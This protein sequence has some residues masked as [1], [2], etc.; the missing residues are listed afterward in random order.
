MK[1]IFLFCSVLL[2]SIGASANN[3]QVS[4]I[5]YNS[6]TG[7]VTFD[8]GWENSWRVST[9][10]NNWDAAWVFIKRRN[11]ADQFW[12]QQYIATSG[13]V[14]ASPLQ[15]VT[16]PDSVGVFIQRSAN[17][18]GNI[19]ATTVTLKLGVVPTPVIEWDFKVFAV[20]M[21]YVPQ[22]AFY[23]GSGG[24][25]YYEF[26]EGNSGAPGTPYLV[27]SENAI[28][29]ANTAGNLWDA[30]TATSNF[31]PT[32]NVVNANFPK[33][34]RAFYAMKYEVT[35]GQ[36]TDFL[37]SLPQD[38]AQARQELPAGASRNNV[39]GTWPTY[40]CTTPNR[41]MNYLSWAD[42]CA[43]LDWSGLAPMSEMEYE[44]L[45]RGV[46]VPVANEFAWGTNTATRGFSLVNDGTPQEEATNAITVGSGLANFNGNAT[47]PSGVFRVGFAAKS[48]TSRTEAGAGY[49]GNMDLTGNVY[50]YCT[51]IYGNATSTFKWDAHGDGNLSLGTGFSNVNGWVNQTIKVEGAAGTAATLKGGG[52]PNRI[53]LLNG[54][55]Q[56]LRVS[57]RLYSNN[58][59]GSNA[60]TYGGRG[61]RRVFN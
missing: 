3:I 55:D 12:K 2:L 38:M 61:V 51:S 50:E 19:S 34:F 5:S 43:Y 14:A 30:G 18:S 60:S 35:Q 58:V 53:G 52:W 27:N 39:T 54:E 13:H 10:P 22:S 6:G 17:G 24:T 42:L 36:Y 47:A 9:I 28:T 11:C 8:I 29:F 16:V 46:S 45:C 33:G 56:S 32:G 57:D 26:R 15:V 7:T 44:K 23:L 49:Y 21:T 31:A 20:E 40:S 1:R 48:A 4:N 41:A 59:Y 37:N 25:N